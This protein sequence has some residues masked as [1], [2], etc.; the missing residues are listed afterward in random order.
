MA[1]NY[2]LKAKKRERAGKGVARSLRREGC[3]PAVIYGDKKDPLNISIDSNDVNVEYYKGR[4][5]TTLC[6]LNVD[7]DKHIV[8]ARDVQLHPV[9]DRVEHV[10]FLRV[11]KKTKLAVKVPVSFI[12]EDKCPSLSQKGTVNVVRHTVELMCSAINI[13]DHVEVSLEDKEHGDAIHLSDIVLPEGAELVNDASLAVATLLPPKTAEEIES[14]E[15]A[16]AGGAEEDGIEE[17]ESEEANSEEES[18]KEE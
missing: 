7:K 6:D 15:E 11:N 12:D 14:E 16:E 5:F 4:M 13:P 8:L 1:N 17:D 9:T 2:A 18:T 10:D 3:I